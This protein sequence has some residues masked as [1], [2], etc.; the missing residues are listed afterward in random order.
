MQGLA[1]VA[2][3]IMLISGVALVHGGTTPRFAIGAHIISASSSVRSV[4]ACFRMT[5]TVAEPVA[6]PA[7]TGQYGLSAGFRAHA[8]LQLQDDIFFNAFEVCSP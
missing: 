2:L 5:A 4:S 6:G 7:S 8:A 1:S 3:L